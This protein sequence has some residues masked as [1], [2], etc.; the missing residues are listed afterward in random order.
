MIASRTIENRKQSG[1]VL[2]AFLLLLVTGAS[3]VFLRGLNAA[4]TQFYRDTQTASALAEAKAALIGRAATDNDRP[5][6]LPCPDIDN[7]GSAELFS[8]TDCP[9]YMGRLPWR[10]LRLSDIRD[11]S[12]ERLWYVLSPTYH[13]HPSAQP[14]NS[15]TL[16]TL[17]VSGT[18]TANDVLAIVIAPGITLGGQERNS[19]A[20]NNVLHYLEGENSDGDNDFVV[21]SLNETFNDQLTVLTWDSLLPTVERRVAGELRN[22]LNNYFANSSATPS[23]RYY[24]YAAKF[25]DSSYTCTFNERHGHVPLAIGSCSGTAVVLPLWFQT[26]NW[27]TVTYYAVAPSCTTTTPG[28]AGALLTVNNSSPPVNNK[29]AI[30]VMTGQKLPG[31]IRPTTNVVDYLEAE[32]GTPND[33]I[34][35]KITGSPTFNDVVTVVA[36]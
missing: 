28:C 8:G 23:A 18:V 21:A 4:A 9:A 31:Q 7:D 16:G 2:V 36:P 22:V 3:F 5:G 13:D 17:A 12:D 24:P 11:G 35:E 14:I 30:V 34:F 29:Q 25:D 27:H 32:N 6:T 19:A 26:N 20:I 15:N 10:T 33:D 1:V